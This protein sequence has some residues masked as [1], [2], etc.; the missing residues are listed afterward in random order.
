MLIPSQLVELAIAIELDSST[1]EWTWTQKD[2]MR[3]YSDPTGKKLILLSGSLLCHDLKW[4]KSEKTKGIA[5]AKGLYARFQGFHSSSTKAYGIKDVKFKKVGTANFIIYDSDKWENVMNRY[6]HTFKGKPNVWV[7]NPKK[8]QAII[9]SGGKLR[10]TA[11][12][13]VG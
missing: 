8:P 13:I 4:S 12:G 11:R 7:D 6:I 2:K 10:V 3:L 5:K 9:L 1:W